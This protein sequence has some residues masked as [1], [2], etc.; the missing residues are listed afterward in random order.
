MFKYLQQLSILRFS[1]NTIVVLAAHPPRIPYCLNT[2]SV[3]LKEWMNWLEY[4]HPLPL[5]HNTYNQMAT[6]G[7]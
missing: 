4:A 6:D 7:V 3:E 2:I 1:N 5:E